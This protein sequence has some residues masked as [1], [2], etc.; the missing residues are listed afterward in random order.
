VAFGHRERRAPS[1]F[2]PALP[3]AE[4]GAIVQSGVGVPGGEQVAVGALDDGRSVG[5]GLDRREDLFGLEPGRLGRWG[6]EGE[7]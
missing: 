6:C 5:L 4:D 3:R 1:G 2:A 7:E